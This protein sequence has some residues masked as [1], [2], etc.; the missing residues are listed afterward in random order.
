M[1]YLQCKCWLTKRELSEQIVEL[2]DSEVARS[3]RSLLYHCHC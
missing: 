2:L 3:I 1:V